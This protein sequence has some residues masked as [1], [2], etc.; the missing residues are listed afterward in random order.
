[1]AAVHIW[2][3]IVQIAPR[4][5]WNVNQFAP[6]PIVMKWLQQNENNKVEIEIS[7]NLYPGQFS[8]LLLLES[9]WL[10][11]MVP[12]VDRWDKLLG[13]TLGPRCW[14][15]WGWSWWSYDDYDCHMMITMMMIKMINHNDGADSRTTRQAI[16]WTQAAPG[17]PSDFLWNFF[18]IGS[19]SGNL[20]M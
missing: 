11:L 7:I 20:K 1:M 6:S 4:L 12:T 8:S 18:S 13:E 2:Y 15:W 3:L 17:S 9:W 19:G 5:C 10:L 16:M 14:W